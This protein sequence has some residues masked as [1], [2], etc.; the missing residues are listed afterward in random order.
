MLLRSAMEKED[1]GK[2]KKK[3]KNRNRR[4][5]DLSY[6][7]L[8]TG[9]LYLFGGNYRTVYKDR[10]IYNATIIGKMRFHDPIIFIE[11]DI[12]RNEV[13]KTTRA[14]KK[15]S[16]SRKSVDAKIEQLKKKNKILKIQDST[17]SQKIVEIHYKSKSPTFSGMLFVGYGDK[18]GW[19]NIS[20]MTKEEILN[21]FRKVDASNP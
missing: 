18:F 15:F 21:Q 14:H 5:L 7:G 8:E 17:I 13:V 3:K 20:Q 6:L 11:G 19:I 10:N 1:S 12:W 4:I 9:K 16:D 2:V